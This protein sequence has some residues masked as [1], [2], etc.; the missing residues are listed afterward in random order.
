LRAAIRPSSHWA[1]GSR[2]AWPGSPP[3]APARR[4]VGCRVDGQIITPGALITFTYFRFVDPSAF[5]GVRRPPGPA[6]DAV[7]RRA[8]QF[9]WAIAAFNLLGWTLAGLIWG[10]LWPLLAGI[11]EP[12]QALRYALG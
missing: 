4:P 10:L 6:G 3:E 8:L 2:G 5:A 7:R 1:P 9:P 12:A 11:Y